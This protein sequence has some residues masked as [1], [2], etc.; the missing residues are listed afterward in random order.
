MHRGRAISGVTQ[1]VGLIGDPVAHS[2]SPAMQNAAFAAAGLDW[3]YLAW[4]VA[5][6]ALP[7]A[8]AGLR[9]LRVR[10]FNVTI[11]HKVAILPLLDE[12]A[13]EAEAIGAVNTVVGRDGRWRG[14]NTDAAGFLRSLVGFGVDPGGRRVVLLG[15][16]GAARA[17]GYALV[18]SG[19]A[20]LHVA[21]RTEERAHRLAEAL[22]VYGTAALSAG[23]L[24]DRA[25]REVLAGADLI[26]DATSTGLAGGGTPVP[27]EWLPPGRFY[28]LLAYGPQMAPLLGVLRERGLWAVDGEEMLLHQGALAFE[29]WTGHP[30]PLDAMREALHRKGDIEE[31]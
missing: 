8:V 17:V 29:Q 27:L 9:A 19:A 24:G 3:V 11:P 26:I 28:Y 10:G 15:A 14:E 13:P 18:R 1:V 21:N 7:A 30:P 23:G 6:E 5:S 20:A 31:E 2:Q 25:L 12:L 4:R 16:G 22:R